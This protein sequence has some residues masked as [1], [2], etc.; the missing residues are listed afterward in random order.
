MIFEDQCRL[1]NML[2]KIN[3]DTTIKDYLVEIEEFDK[4]QRRNEMDRRN[5]MLRAKREHEKSKV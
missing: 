3:P 5:Y 1:V 2:I 4:K